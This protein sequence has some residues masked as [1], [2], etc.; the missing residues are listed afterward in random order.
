MQTQ[1]RAV[2]YAEYG[3]PEVLRVESVPIEEPG[4]SE[5]RLRV[6]AAAIN[7]KDVLVRKGK[8]RWM[9]GR[10]LPR[11]TGYD[12]AGVVERAGDGADLEV[13]TRVFGML[14]RQ[15]GGAV[16]EHLVAPAV[17]MA[18]IPESV[19]FESAAAIPLAG[20]TALQALRDLAGVRSGHTVW[21]HGAS[22]GVGTFAIQVAKLLG[23]RVTT[24]SSDANRALCT[25]LGA[26][27]T[28]D[29]RVD[30][31]EQSHAAYDAIFDVFGNRGFAMCRDALRDPGTFVSTVPSP[32]IALDRIRTQF[33]SRRARLILVRSNRRDLEW[34]AEKAE[35][36]D[37]EP[38]VDRTF[39]LDEVADAHAYIE[40]KRARGKVV[41]TID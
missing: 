12:F 4:P 8:L 30:H 15:S 35:A 40:T 37:L 1:T 2:R 11:L 10:T 7:P 19:S 6:R 5:V 23:A 33:A 32:R 14:N 24:T 21:I 26:D 34:L 39:S 38:R 28:L 16:A 17:E 18:V 22:G 20:Q 29:Y 13:G 25:S 41:I 36:G 3:P 27:K 9:V 31:P